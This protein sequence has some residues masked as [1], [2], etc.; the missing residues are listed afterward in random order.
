[1]IPAIR[2]EHP[3]F[4]FI[5]EAYWD[6]ECELQQKGFDFCYDK[7]LYDRLEH[8]NAENIRLHLCADV[9]YQQKLLRFIENHDQPPPAAATFSAQKERAAVVTMATLPGAKLFHEGQF[10]GRKMRP[11]VFLG[12]RPPE[13]PDHELQSFYTTRLEAINNPVFRSGE[14]TLCERTGWPEN[15]SFQNLVAWTWM[16]DDERYLI[17]VNLSSGTVQ[18]R[19][20]IPWRDLRGETWRLGDMLSG[21]T[22]D[23]DGDEMRAPGLDEELGPW[24]FT[25]SGVVPFNPRGNWPA[26]H[27]SPQRR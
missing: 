21:E 8:C 17:V 5:A 6:L 10:V 16:K 3:A 20:H 26:R 7:K 2:K 18:A 23:R 1:M 14:W 22:Y 13:R 9:A 27:D 4:L 15:S 12:R 24:K 11:P 25:S 19:V